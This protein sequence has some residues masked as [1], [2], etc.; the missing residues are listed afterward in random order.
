M[1]IRFTLLLLLLNAIAFSLILF[2]NQRSLLDDRNALRLAENIRD[3]VAGAQQI[4]LSG[5]VINLAHTLDRKGEKWQITQPFEWPA[6]YFSV[7]RILNQLQFIEEDTSFSVSTLRES[8]QTLADY[9]FD[10]P[11]LKI[12]LVHAKGTR[13]LTIGTPTEIGNKLYLLGPEQT[14][15]YVVNRS[16]IDSLLMDLEALRARDI[17]NLPVFEIDTLELETKSGTGTGSL[18]VRLSKDET[19]WKFEAPIAASADP[20]LVE[21]TINSLSSIQVVR[22]VEDNSSDPVAQGLND[23]FIRITLF[24]NKREQT[25]LVG[26]PDPSAQ[27][28]ATYFA[29]LEALPTVFTIPAQTIDTLRQAQQDLRKRDF[30]EFD[31][32]AVNSLVIRE[33]EK[34]LRLQKL[35]TGNWQVISKAPERDI[36]TRRADAAHVSTLLRDLSQLRALD[37]IMDNPSPADLGQLHLN[38]PQRSIELTLLD[39]TSHTL[40]LAH[41]RDEEEKLFAQNPKNPFVYEVQREPLLT[42]LSLAPIDYYEKALETLPTSARVKS[43]RIEPRNPD[44]AVRDIDLDSESGR[45]EAAEL[46]D[47]VRNFRVHAYLENEYQATREPDPWEYDLIATLL[48][49]DGNGGRETTQLYALTRR[50]GATRQIGGSPAHNCTF[51]LS[52][53][54]IEALHPFLQTLS[55]PPEAKGE[56]VTPPTFPEPVPLPEPAL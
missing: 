19:L 46:I 9:G 43:L 18:K 15:V 37:F 5:R 10:D 13:A 38:N 28:E 56:A 3:E 42:Q 55:L 33:K 22:F 6:N 53:K 23:P 29:R 11:L 35:E 40:I 21:S 1:R 30:F 54:M 52:Q 2:L 24:G 14:T 39:A 16:S 17:F 25:L 48:L 26:N 34:E 7:N 31:P 8:G 49:P 44:L 47:C 27:G 20:A 32:G 4:Q 12:S 36:Q 51:E 45:T 41:P 50:L